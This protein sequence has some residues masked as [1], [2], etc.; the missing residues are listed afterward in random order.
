MAFLRSR[1]NLLYDVVACFFCMCASFYLR[2]GELPPSGYTLLYFL[3]V[4]IVAVLAQ[5]LSFALVGLYRGL[6]RYSSIEDLLQIVKSVSLA[7]VIT[8]LSLFFFNRLEGIP[9]SVFIID[10]L[11]L[12]F[13]LGGGRLVYRVFKDRL[14]SKKGYSLS[15]AI[16]VGA[17]AAGEQLLREVSR[18]GALGLK[19]VGFIDDDKLKLGRKI[20]GVSVLGGR[21]K[22]KDIVL[23]NDVRQVFIAISKSNKELVSFIYNT[24][25]SVEGIDI[26]TMPDISHLVGGRVEI[27]LFRDL[28]IEDL[29]GRKEVEINFTEVYEMIF[30]KTILVT[31]AGGSIGSELCRQILNFNPKLLICIDNSELNLYNLSEELGE[32][33]SARATFK[34][35]DVRDKLGLS[36]IFKKYN[37]QLVF[38]AAAYKHVPIMEDSPLE[39]LKTNVFG[40]FNVVST[41]EEFC[42]EDFVLISTDKAVNPTNIMGAS[43]R[44]AEFVV[45]NYSSKMKSR[46]VRFG[47]VLGSSGSVVPVF[48]KQIERGGPVTVTHPEITRFFMSIPEAARLVLQAGAFGA[49]GEVFIL[50]MGEPVKIYDLAL[51]MIRIAGLVPDRDITIEFSGL[52]PGEK[53]FEELLLESEPLVG[54][55]HPKIKIAKN[56]L[57]N[58]YNVKKLESLIQNL[59][60][61]QEREAFLKVNELV[62]EF[63]ARQEVRT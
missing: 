17:G 53:L 37:P 9:R 19:I 62:P 44:I 38:H 54:T 58:S 2:L 51:E 42:A 24:L 23:A 27:S 5:S 15:N 33:N 35:C 47:N 32:L 29:L 41:A 16:V 6:W 63:Q 3:K 59:F 34:I 46:L 49:G 57:N 22:I 55:P 40:T 45:N 14:K 20:R 36:Q 4:L 56:K 21:E 1:L 26:K 28:K 43:K 31:G 13:A 60:Y 48:R 11:L 25:K 61:L 7:I 30:N 39:A 10:W 18:S 12:I 50:D 52:R 8:V